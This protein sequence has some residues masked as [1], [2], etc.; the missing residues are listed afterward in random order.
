MPGDDPK[1]VKVNGMSGTR[2]DKKLVVWGVE[3]MEPATL[4]QARRA[5]HLPFV[6]GHVALMPS[7]WQVSVRRRT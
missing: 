5:S 2:V 6:A 7:P 4:D 1:P 3:S